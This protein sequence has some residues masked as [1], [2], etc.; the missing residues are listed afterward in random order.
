MDFTGGFFPQ[1][2]KISIPEDTEIIFVSDMFVEQYPYG[3]AEKSS[4]ALIKSSPFKVF[5]LQSKDISLELLEQGFNRY[6][7]FGNFTAMDYKLIPS[8]IANLK[9]SIIEYDYKFCRYRSTIKHELAEQQ[10]CNCDNE[11][12][13]KLIS[14]FFYGSKSI[15]WMSEKQREIYHNLF[16][17]LAEKEDMILSSVFDDEFFV[18]IKMLREKYANYDRREWLVLDSPSWIK[19]ADGCAKFCEENNLPYKKIWG[20]EYDMLLTELAKAKGAV[21]LYNSPD[22][23]PRFHIECVLLGGKAVVNEH[24]QH[25]DELWINEEASILDTE[26]YLFLSRERFWND[27]KRNMNLKMPTI[28]AYTTTRNVIYQKYPWQESIQSALS[29]CD[30][31]VVYDTSDLDENNDETL[32]YLQE[33]EGKEPKLKVYHGDAPNRKNKDWALGDG[34]AKAISRCHASSCDYLIQFDIDEIL[35]PRKELWQNLVKNFPNNCDLLC[36]PVVE[37]WGKK[38]IRCDVNPH[39][40]RISRNAPHITH[41]VPAELRQFRKETGEMF[42]HPPFA[43]DGCDMIRFDNFNRIPFLNF[44]NQQEVDKVRYFALQGNEEARKRYEEWTE[45]VVSQIPTIFHLSWISVENKMLRYKADEENGGY[46]WQDAWM[47]LYNMKEG[48]LP[49]N[50]NFF[51]EQK[52]AD[53]SKEEVKEKAQK[54]EE[55]LGGWIFHRPVDLNA[56]VPHINLKNELIPDFIKEIIEKV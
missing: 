51:P 8:V 43:S 12:N 35:D 50:N 34:N 40:V 26:S 29:I 44:Y 54:I 32:K 24:I 46:K 6:W 1:S 28:G 38:K 30:E 53:V 27:V 45:R 17:F 2:K 10:K 16:P 22:S 14:A 33:W 36:L 11:E 23:C 25:A 31:V 20:L 13:G 4:E 37:W 47:S 21:M 18:K 56:N 55:K 7:I 39:K 3:G 15:Y 49:K 9:Y 19:N 42:V 52:W 48:D 5:K 41:G